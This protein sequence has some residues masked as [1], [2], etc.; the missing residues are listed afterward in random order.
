MG[1]T[2]IRSYDVLSKNQSAA[3]E[4]LLNQSVQSSNYI[5]SYLQNLIS[6]GPSSARTQQALNLYNQ[7]FVPQAIS[8]YGGGR[9]SS[10]LNQALASGAQNLS[11]NLSADTMNAL[12]LLQSLSQSGTAA[13]LGTQT[14][15]YYSAPST[16]SQTLAGLLQLLS[17]GA[18]FA[19]QNF[20]PN[21]I[22]NILDSWFKRS[23]TGI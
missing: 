12:Q 11:Q 21:L 17:S 7:Q 10:A 19:G 18:S 6:Q 2:R 14:K 16:G 15:G 3:L 1:Q 8:Q 22:P 9:S 5:S 4:N 13:G 23:N 20:L